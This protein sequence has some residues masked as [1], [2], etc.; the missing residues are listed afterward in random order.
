[1][2]DILASADTYAR[3]I[4]ACSPADVL[5]G[6][7]SLGYAYGLGSL[8]VFPLRFGARVV[9]DATRSLDDLLDAIQTHRV[10]IMFGSAT[11]YR[12]MLRMP[13]LERRFDLRSLRLCVSAGEALDAETAVEW[14]SRTGAEL[15][16]SFGTT[17]MCH[18]FLSQRPG[19]VV[20]GTLGEAVPGYEIRIVNEE[21]E[22]VTAGVPGRLAVHGPTSCRYWRR[23]AA[24]HEYVRGGW[25]ITGDI[26]V[27]DESGHIRYRGRDDNLIVSAGHNIS[28]AEVAQVL[29]EHP[30]VLDA[31]VSGD[32][33]PIRGAVPKAFVVLKPDAIESAGLTLAIQQHV[34]R[35]LASYKC[36]RRMEFVSELPR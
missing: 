25:N 24:Q 28:S 4:L 15:I 10:T 23:P 13:Y 16:D 19:L 29:R 11:S 33:D 3:S 27:R 8:L 35:E 26:C 31:L 1:M 7:L 17:E 22:D 20:P 2:S 36:P 30:A 18:V 32:S 9:L 34:Q 21:L 14:R 12:L 5:A 6:H